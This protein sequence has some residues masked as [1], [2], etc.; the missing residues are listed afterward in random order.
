[1]R[2]L[3]ISALL[4]ATASCAWPPPPPAEMA[5]TSPPPPAPVFYVPNP[6][7]L[8]LG[9]IPPGAPPPPGRLTLSNFTFE[10]ARVEALITPYPD[11]ALREGTAASAFELPLNG[12]RVIEA[13][14]GT[15]VCW[16]RQIEPA[17][18]QDVAP[19]APGWSEWN[20]VFTSSGRSIDSRL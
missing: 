2:I 3:L 5:G 16:R 15:D 13:A 19:S 18:D 10:H 9:A 4:V 14:L 8:L 17:K 12:T 6:F 20:R 11:C 7:A 1:V